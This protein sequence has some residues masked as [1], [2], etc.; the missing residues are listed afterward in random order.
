[1]EKVV[2]FV[3]SEPA[4][5]QAVV[6]A[7]L[8]LAVTLGADANLVTTIGGVVAALIALAGGEAVRARVAPVATLG[9]HSH[10]DMVPV[11]VDEDG[12]EIDTA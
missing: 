4:R 10:E 5:V 9:D 3:R 11:I 8:L 7:L 2:T 6:A 1:M 12:E